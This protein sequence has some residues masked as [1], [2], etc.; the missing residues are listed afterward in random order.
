MRKHPLAGAKQGK[1]FGIDLG[2]GSYGY[3]RIFRGSSLGVLPII[4]DK[5]FGNVEPLRDLTPES[6][7]FFAAPP[8]DPTEMTL[9]GEI[10]FPDQEHAEPPPC[11]S[12]PDKFQSHYRI[13]HR[14]IYREGTE[15]DVAGMAPCRRASPA[16]L[17]EFILS[18]AAQFAKLRSERKK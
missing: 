14:G 5:L 3:L 6:F 4:T 10:P 18:K 17:R 1:V 12:A 2:N 15:A 7:F 11:F 8:D 13:Y 9:I 16:K